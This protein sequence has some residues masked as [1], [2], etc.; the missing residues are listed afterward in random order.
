MENYNQ[1]FTLITGASAGIG[2]AFANECARRHMNLALVALPGYQLVSLSESLEKAYPIRVIHLA[3][4]L[5]EADAPQ[6]VLEWCQQENIKVN[7]LINN[8]GFG[9][10]GLLESKDYQFY[11]KMMQL[12]NQ[13]MVGM[14]YH[15]LPELKKHS[16]SYLL[17]MSS[18]EAFMPLPYKAV[19]AATKNFVYAFSLALREEL[20]STPVKVSVVC[21]GPTV[22]NQDGLSRIKAHGKRS[23]LMV[24]FP[25]DVAKIAMRQMMAGKV[26]I[27]PGSMNNTIKRI[28]T[29]LPTLTKMSLL[30]SMF[31]VY[32]TE[33]Q[34]SVSK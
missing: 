29:F 16:K 22:T 26:V 33:D 21:P 11:L 24:M 14:T 19:Y 2:R 3:I 30:E 32:K 17:N 27:V 8:A 31:R 15:F 20:K 28:M 7:V 5:T 6:R 12:N 23:R 13:A 25:K 18:L 1:F 34:A 10:N 9:S 4:D